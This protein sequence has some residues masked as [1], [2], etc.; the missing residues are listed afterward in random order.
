M[1]AGTQL[2]QDVDFAELIR[3]EIPDYDTLM[4]Q[5]DVPLEMVNTLQSLVAQ[6]MFPE[7]D[8][9]T[10]LWRIG[11]ISFEGFRQTNI[12]KILL[13]AL[14]V[15]GTERTIKNIPQVFNG[16]LR[17]GT[18]TVTLI[19]AHHY[20]LSLEDTPNHFPFVAGI[21]EGALKGSGASNIEIKISSTD[22]NQAVFDILWENSNT[23][24]EN[25]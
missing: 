10:A 1:L 19:A 3:R 17:Y 22:P 18:R 21:I 14:S 5:A 2:N 23:E 8:E 25:I 4:L 16:V 24:T 7:L 9:A 12:G 6:R 20:Q 13:A 11:Y 15:W